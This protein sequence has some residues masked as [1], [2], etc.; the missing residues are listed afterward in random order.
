MAG[1]RTAVMR[2]TITGID[3]TELEFTTTAGVDDEVFDAAG[4]GAIE[5]DP[6]GNAGASAAYVYLNA[7]HATDGW[8]VTGIGSDTVTSGRDVMAVA[9][10]IAQSVCQEINRGLG[11]A[12]TPLQE[13]TAVVT[14]TAFNGAG[15][16]DNAGTFHSHNAAPQPYACVDNDPTAAVD[17]TYYHVLAEQ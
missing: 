6:P 13:A 16:A 15:A 14:G 9:T 12:T 4:G 5:Q 10:D 17:Y 2:M 1:L 11:L 8:Y 7:Q 3:E